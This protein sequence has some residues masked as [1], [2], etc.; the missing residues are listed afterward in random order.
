MIK[1]TED[2]VIMVNMGSMGAVAMFDRDGVRKFVEGNAEVVKKP[3]PKKVIK[4]EK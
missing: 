2:E 4:K 1:I 3:V